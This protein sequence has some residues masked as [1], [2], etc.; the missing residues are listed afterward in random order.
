MVNAMGLPNPGAEVAARNLSRQPV[1]PAPRFVSLADE[2]LQD[3][4]VALDLLAPLA[5]GIE[6]NASCPNVSWGRDR[7]NEAHLRELV[8]AFVARTP[9]PVFVKL[10]RFA[11]DTERDVV[12]ALARIARDAGAAGLTCS[13]TMAVADR[14]VSA[15]VGGLSGRALWPG[16]TA[17]VSAVRAAIGSE[18]PV[19]ACGGVV[20]AADA[21]ACI[22][23]GATTIQLYTGLIYEG[24]GVV[25]R[26]ASGLAAGPTPA[27]SMLPLA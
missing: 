22:E 19:N 1:G 13:N 9:R 27:S 16:T 6:L 2:A 20:T 12:L 11:S 14:R 3:A 7:D 4:V 24:P 10:P 25:G 26:L 21:L 23:A 18:L 15:G 8:T 5:D 17:I